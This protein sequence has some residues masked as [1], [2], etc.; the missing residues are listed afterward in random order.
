[1]S[2]ELTRRQL[3]EAGIAGGAAVGAYGVVS[4][5]IA[6]AL[7]AAPPK[8][9]RLRDIEHVVILIQENRSFDCYFGTYRGVR[10]FADPHA[11]VLHDGSG[12]NVFH[13][14]GYPAAGYGGRLLPFRLDTRH[15]GA[16]TSDVNLSYG[17][18]HAAWNGGRMDGF[19]RAHLTAD[20]PAAG[21]LAMGYYTRQDM[22]FH[23]AL[24]DAFTLYDGY[25]CS[26][27]GPTDPNRLYS[28]SGTLDP[29]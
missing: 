28:L 2:H 16:C 29:D 10:G 4:G 19:V 26:V 15:G 17:P 11:P 23:H 21:P 7:A 24:A 25:F 22:P 9:G 20:G 8:C 18:Q 14:P 5:T 6:R 3:L 12:L 27:I 13:Q 1:M